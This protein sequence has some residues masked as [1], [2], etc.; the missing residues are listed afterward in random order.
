MTTD[1]FVALV[2]SWMGV[3]FRHQ[4]R[5]REGVDC[6]GLVICVVREAGLIP[7]DWDV[8]GYSHQ[9]DGSMFKVCGD[10]LPEAPPQPGGVFVMRFAKEP[11]H[12]GFFAPYGDGRLSMIHALSDSGK[13]VEHRL[14]DI[15]KRRLV[16]TF[17]V[18]G[19]D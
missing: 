9:P 7:P 1:E 14:D 2:R 12:M 6:A 10:M 11:Q 8:N 15:W 19:V 5:S 17:R 4:G 16:G 18:P 3:P 13:V